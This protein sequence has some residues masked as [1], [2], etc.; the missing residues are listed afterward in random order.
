MCV[1][2]RVCARVCVLSPQ[3]TSRCLRSCS[4]VLAI[5]MMRPS[6]KLTV[7]WTLLFASGLGR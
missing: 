7:V 3:F 2:V 5:R 4:G 1:C 6:L